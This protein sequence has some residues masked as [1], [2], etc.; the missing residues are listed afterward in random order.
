MAKN[1]T[2]PHLYP[3]VM[4]GGKGTRFW[5][6]SR[7][8]YPKQ[9]LKLAGERSLLQDTLMRLIDIAKKGSVHIVTTEAQRDL[10]NWQAR[11]VLSSEKDFSTVVEPEGKNT[12]PAIALMAHRWPN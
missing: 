8:K 1:T 7:E 10:V 11:E 6:L 9:Y 3:V 12:A 4:A 5:P 2:I